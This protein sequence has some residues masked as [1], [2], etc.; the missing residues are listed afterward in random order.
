LNDLPFRKESFRTVLCLNV[1]HQ[2]ADA[3]ALLS[4]LNELLSRR[5]SLYLTSLISN[6]RTIGDWYLKTLYQMG[7]FVRPR[8]DVELTE[9]FVNTF[10]QQVNYSEKGNMAFVTLSV[11]D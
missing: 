5:G 1:L 4:G 10:G 2:F 6:N 11:P 7:E 9:A 8:T 3:K